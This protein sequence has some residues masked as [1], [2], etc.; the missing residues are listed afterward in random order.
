[1]SGWLATGRLQVAEDHPSNEGVA[2][3]TW[4]AAQRAAVIEEMNLILAHPIFK[5]S[6]RCTGLLR[7]LI[8]HALAGKEDEIK[9]RTLGIEVFGR[10][11]TYDLS[12]D[13]IVR[14]VASEI[15]KRLA[16]YYQEGDSS[17][18]VRI[19]LVRG[20]YLPAFEFPLE[21]GGHASIDAKDTEE[22]SESLSQPEPAATHVEKASDS[23]P[24]VLRHKWILGV[25]AAVLVSAACYLPIRLNVFHTPEYRVWKPLLDASDSITVCLP[26]NTPLVNENEKSI[27]KAVSDMIASSQIPP[28]DVQRDHAPSTMFRDARV[29]NNI[30][31]LLSNYKRQVNLRSPSN[32]KFWDFHQKP[33]VL[34]GGI[35]NPW[36]PIFFSRL[37]YSVRYDPATLDRWIQDAQNPSNR[38]WKIDGKQESNPPADYAIVSRIFDGDSGQWI[39][40]LSGLEGYGTEAAAQLVGDPKVAKLIPN[41]VHEQGNFQIVLRTSIIGGEPGPLQVLAVQTW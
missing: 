15:R 37:R 9:E 5:T 11:A 17:H 19:Q 3:R 30:S 23:I 33:V 28:V 21:D 38:D 18:K 32:L 31:T 4:S 13:P 40:A 26:D 36:V 20:G 6:N 22:P 25:A 12:T 7:Y 24:K 2:S 29:S 1:M 34:I 10:S 14:R 16:Q 35:N 41:S 27:P 8:D 39:M